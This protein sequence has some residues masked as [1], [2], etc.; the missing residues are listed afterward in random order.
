LE[1]LHGYLTLAEKLYDDGQNFS[2]AW[3]FGPEQADCV[4]VLDIANKLIEIS[5]S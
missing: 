2:D 1:P 3:N 5:G 4:S